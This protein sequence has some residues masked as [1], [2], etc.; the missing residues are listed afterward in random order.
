[1]PDQGVYSFYLL[2]GANMVQVCTSTFSIFVKSWH[3]SIMSLWG[4]WG[5][6]NH[7][8]RPRTFHTLCAWTSRVDI[9]IIPIL[10]PPHVPTIKEMPLIHPVQIHLHILQRGEGN[11]LPR[12]FLQEKEMKPCHTCPWPALPNLPVVCAIDTAS[13]SF[14]G[15]M[16]W[17][18]Q[19]HDPIQR[20]NT[21]LPHLIY[22]YSAEF[23]LHRT[24][25]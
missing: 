1:M 8:K 22:S 19:S 4:E 13:S 5:V 3:G 6:M 2:L 16:T 7:L 17:P 18:V 14:T 11:W 10:P 23:T 24:W 12:H 21:S 20:R 25:Q 15:A 9:H